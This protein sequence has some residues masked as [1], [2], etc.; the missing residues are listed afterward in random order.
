MEPLIDDD[1]MRGFKDALERFEANM[2]AAFR[3]YDKGPE[4]A[5]YIETDA[6][7]QLAEIA[8]KN[9]R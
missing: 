7:R 2:I 1:S 6:D 5:P 8:P 4:P 9:R 3:S